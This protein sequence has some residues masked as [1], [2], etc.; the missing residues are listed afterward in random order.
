MLK[1]SEGLVTLTVCNPNKAKDD[2]KPTIDEPAAAT[3][4]AKSNSITSHRSEL[5]GSSLEVV[6]HISFIL[7]LFLNPSHCFV[8]F[9]L[10]LIEDFTQQLSCFHSLAFI[11]ITNFFRENLITGHCSVQI[12]L[13]YLKCLGAS[14]PVTPKPTPSP[15]KEPPADPLTAAIHSNENTTIEIVAVNQPLGV[16]VVG[17]NDTHVPVSGFN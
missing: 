8:N 13:S 9:K 7:F 14:R 15:A 4:D 5:K 3:N 16:I 11:V 12:Q 10:Q 1:K 17:G 6:W 2:D